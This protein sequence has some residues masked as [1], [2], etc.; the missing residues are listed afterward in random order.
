MKRF[1]KL[2]IVTLMRATS[3]PAAIVIIVAA[4]LLLHDPTIADAQTD[5]RAH[6]QEG[7]VAGST[8]SESAG[9]RGRHMLELPEVWGAR[10]EKRLECGRGGN[11]HAKQGSERMRRGI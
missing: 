4:L 10:S 11:G 6:R 2:D 3:M 1:I 8:P 5:H 7:M 9:S